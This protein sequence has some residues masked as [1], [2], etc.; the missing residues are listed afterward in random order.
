[1]PEPELKKVYTPPPRKR[2]LR[3]FAFDPSQSQQY[4]NVGINH[5]VLSIPWE[6]LRDGP[7]G[8][9]LEVID[10]DP[11]SGVFYPPVNLNEPALLAQDG[12]APS[13]DN[14]QFHQQMVYAVVMATI[15]RFEK[16]LGRRVVW[17]EAVFDEQGG[18]R[19]EYVRR[20]RIYPHAI[21]RE[22][23]F[24][25]PEKKALMFGYFP[26]SKED[27]NNVVEGGRV[28]TC[29]AH[30]IIVH[31]A[32]HAILDGMQ[33]LFIHN[34]NPD[35]R[36]LHEALADIMA[37][38]ER[39]TLPEVVAHEIAR[40]RGNLNS[41]TLLSQIAP[42]FGQ[43]VGEKKSLRDVIGKVDS[44]GVWSRKQPD[45]REYSTVF[46]EHARAEILVG[47]VVDAFLAMY[48]TRS[49]DL[50]RI[51]TRGRGELPEGEVPSPDLVSRLVKEVTHAADHTLNMCIR[52]IDY[53]PPVD[54]NF[55]EF[56]RALITA[57]ADM[58][59]E[60]RFNYRV[61]FIEAFWRHG[62][63]IKNVRSLSTESLLW[64]PPEDDYLK[65]VSDFFGGKRDLRSYAPAYLKDPVEIF[66]H[67]AKS[68]G[69]LKNSIYASESK[70]KQDVM[71]C[72]WL[73]YG[74][75]TPPSVLREPGGR[76]RIDVQSVHPALRYT[77][78]GVQVNDLIIQL[79]QYRLG[80]IDPDQQAQMDNGQAYCTIN[81][82]E[83]LDDQHFLLYGGCTLIFNLDTGLLRYAIG[84]R[85]DSERRLNEA[86]DQALKNWK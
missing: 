45:P 38:F 67:S 19:T 75:K 4:A 2:R 79:V 78:E 21:R 40:A 66:L 13:E 57:D 16:G 76:P 72:M 23:A 3:V 9:Y 74:D 55:G 70:H 58:V 6:E 44:A 39:F 36:A 86:R 17:S 37:F 82:Q 52:A 50:I 48:N 20:L 5:M 33:S 65:M 71:N 56:L 25:S 62:I 49:A 10:V 22:D 18:K 42:Q 14:P 31:E 8:E 35:M 51:A 59:P 68:R 7:V 60:D 1:M 32:T 29:L 77:P 34:S 26:T 73:A 47:A 81:P 46:E 43:A 27:P 61:A 30:D 53:L 24:Y 84:K 28:F 80:C 63:K 12:L 11:A 85:V 54:V 83:A 69:A 15:A 64:R 41:E